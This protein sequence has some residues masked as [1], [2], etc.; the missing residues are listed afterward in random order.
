MA[1]P[2]VSAKSLTLLKWANVAAFVLTVVVNSLAGST[3]LIGGVSTASI[4]DSNPTLVT[5]AGYTFS[6]WGIIYFLLGVFVVSQ[7]FKARKDSGGEEKI[8]WLFVL[9]SVMN[10][11]WLIL[12]QYNILGATVIV[13]FL[14]LATLVMI[15]RRLGI[16]ISKASVRER[17]S[18][19][20]PFSVYLGW[21][22][23]AT[24][25]NVSVALV[26][27]GWDGFGIGPETWA[28][29]ILAVALL[30]A[31]LVVARRKDVAYGLVIVWALMGIAAKQSAN[32]SIAVLAQV[33][34][35]AVLL[36]LAATFVVDRFK[37]R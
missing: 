24:I 16:G 21:I 18:V 2:A 17:L 19:H 9:S 30:I 10:I 7:F 22:T 5:P 34:A 25:A 14:L 1:R 26:S 29:A 6:I 32:Q 23:I 13:M 36:A 27:V 37:R 4:S 15:Y 28:K 33:S 11:F 35:I 20:L 12:W 31:L 3:T 8:G